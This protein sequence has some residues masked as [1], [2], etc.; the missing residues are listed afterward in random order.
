M[1]L[2]P[3]IIFTISFFVPFLCHIFA[4]RADESSEPCRIK[5]DSFTFDLTQVAGEH[6]VNRTQDSPP[7]T[8]IESLRFN[9]CAELDRLDGIPDKDQCP[10]GTQACLTKVNMRENEPDRVVS[11]IP[12]AQKEKLEPKY[13]MS[14]SSPKYLSVQLHGPEYPNPLTSFPTPQLL[15]L[16]LFCEPQETSSPKIIAYDFSR[17]DLEWLS[18]AGCS[19]KDDNDV[20]KDDPKGDDSKEEE[21]VGS[22]IGWFFLVVLLAFVGYFGLGAYYNYSTYGA[23]GLDL[24]P[25]RDFWREVPYMIGDVFSHLCSNIRPRRS[26]NRGGYIAV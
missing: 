25:H 24:I 11:V 5:V 22:G 1:I 23:R 15:N 13:A 12:L 19:F 6:I 17:L 21:Q 8:T 2:R 16:T 14:S 9:L 3:H 10:S 4:V 18:P 26:V 7:T 20:P